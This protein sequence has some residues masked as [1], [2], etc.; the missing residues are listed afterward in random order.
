MAT[1]QR[2]GDRYRAIIR[3]PNL[4]ASKSFKRL[5]DARVWAT[6][7][8]RAAD[9]GGIVPGRSAVTIGALIDLYERELWPS[10]R[11]GPTKAQE[12]KVLRR[13]LGAK[14]T[15]QL[16]RTAVSAY[17]RGLKL[18]PASI[19]IRLSYLRDVLRAGRDLFNVPVRLDEVDSAI[20]AAR[21]TGRAGKSSTRD[22]RPTEA[23]L[24]AIIAHAEGN[25]R[26]MI[27]LAAVVR[28]LAVLPLRLGELLA[29]QWDDID[30]ER[31]TVTLRSRKHPDIREKERPQEVP[32]ITFAGIDTFA[33]IDDRPRYMTAPFPYIASSVSAAFTVTC[34]ALKIE[35]L[36]LHDLRAYSISRLL[37]AGVPVPQVALLSGHR[38]WRILA[39]HYARLDAAS[40][41]DTLKRLG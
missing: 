33:L 26:S 41:H 13:D 30:A 6:A 21:R 27:D 25:A 18:G 15:D 17:L 40:V 10:K 35:D 22:R 12:L 20:G 14:L 11:W 32:L 1:F 9:L 39:K 5:G 37:E 36:H 28:V 3:R 34:R 24:K 4:K 31:R 2:R 8:E 7:Q 38:N 19:S 23:E 16:T 29:I